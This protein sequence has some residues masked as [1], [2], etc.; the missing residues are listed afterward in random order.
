MGFPFWQNEPTDS[1]LA[2]AGHLNILGCD[3]IVFPEVWQLPVDSAAPAVQWFVS[4]PQRQLEEID[5]TESGVGR[6]SSNPSMV[7]AYGVDPPPPRRRSAP[8]PIVHRCRGSELRMRRKIHP[9][10]MRLLGE[11]GRQRKALWLRMRHRSPVNPDGSAETRLN[12]LAG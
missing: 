12:T 4:R 7:S 11:C 2:G 9:A 8:H 6:A 1:F 3:N 10:H 5:T